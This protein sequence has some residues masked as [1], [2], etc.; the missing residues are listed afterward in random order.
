MI[1]A[2]DDAGP[3]YTQVFR[4]LR[5]SILD[6]RLGVGERLPSS[7]A[8][9]RDVNLSRNTV[10]QAYEMLVDEGYA[11]TRGGAGTFVASEL[12][13][14]RAAIRGDERA[15]EPASMRPSRPARL[16]DQA[17]RLLG[18]WG[19]SRAS[20]RMK[21]P[22][23]RYDFRYGEPRYEDFPL[24]TWSRLLEA[25]A[26]SISRDDLGY[27]DGAG[28]P[29]LR[30]A[31]AKYLVRSRGVTCDP[32]D[33]IVVYGT[34]QAIDLVAR[35]VVDPG[36]RVAIEEPGYL[37]IHIA[38]EAAGAEIVP[39][40]VD[41]Q[42]LDVDALAREREISLVCLTPSHQF[43]TGV[44]MPAGRRLRLLEWADRVDAYV[45]E[46]DY[47]SEFN[48]EGSPVPSLQGLDR[49]GCVIHA[50]T[51]SKV[52]FP[53]LR[54]GFIVPPREL[55]PALLA[56]KVMADAGCSGI[57]Q[58]AMAAFIEEGHFD[59]HLRRS[60]THASRKR[61][62][63]LAALHESFGDRVHVTGANAGLHVMLWL[64]D[65]PGTDE[66]EICRR[67]REVDVGVYPARNAFMR[68]PDEAVLLL[69]YG[70]LD[71]DSIREGVRR[72]ATVLDD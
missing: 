18:V 10:L 54:L 2:L 66:L 26:R 16:S 52:M 62:V 69:G 12:P 59:A 71:E 61:E 72:L 24:P 20:W 28:H 56:A 8:L 51:L 6:G 13:E 60:R 1:L 48:F 14:D 70:A 30:I 49:T 31:L 17:S 7:R 29:R 5:R 36:R 39:I 42:G 44:V 21:R 63:M 41:A 3:L 46:D 40:P 23:V 64:L 4:A 45:L 68:P 32:D 25:S 15:A 55:Y 27:G 53:A 37:G 47:D 50:G 34:Q 11:V 33:I 58:R 19:N 35:V 38:L 22:R 9:A 57:E 65:R 43:P 67:A